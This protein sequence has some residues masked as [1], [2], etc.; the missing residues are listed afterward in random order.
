MWNNRIKITGRVCFLTGNDVTIWD[1]IGWCL[2]L[3]WMWKLWP[4][5][6]GLILPRRLVD[7]Q[8][9]GR[10]ESDPPLVSIIVPA[11][12][13]AAAIEEALRRMLAIDY[14][15]F[16]LIA[17]DDRSSDGTGAIMD[18][19][20]AGDPRCRVIHVADLPAGWLGKNHANR[21]GAREARG[22]YLLFT[23]G[24]VMFEPAILRHAVAAMRGG[25]DHLALFP[26]AMMHGF[27]ESMMMNYFAFQFSF[28]T[29]LSLV[30]FRWAKR[31]FVGIGAFNLVRRSA[32]E[33]AG[34]H[35]R[36]K[37]EVADDLMLGKIV[38]EAG[39]QQD[40]MAGAPLVKV[41]WQSGL[42]GIVR[43]L[44]KNAFAAARYSVP[45]TLTA[46]AIHLFVSLA[47]IALAITGPL[48]LPSIAFVLITLA[49]HEFMAI[50]NRY[51]PLV[52]VLYPVCSVV[53]AYIMARSAYVTLRSGG[54][55]W[56]D[57]FYPLAELR[58][59]MIEWR[60]LR[61]SRRDRPRTV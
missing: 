33:A 11:R 39:F 19:V 14:P 56:R 30:R 58:A 17:I 25:L 49:S 52:A 59:G 27:G 41:K 13:E 36:L 57:S 60:P 53:F 20:A 50:R 45:L 43:G 34:G 26:D 5:W 16:E 51:S 7:V 10:D 8:P 1:V 23:D 28:A 12:D 9:I 2:L 46:I 22:E 47:P 29:Q 38:K 6:Y 42:W 4:I 35:E 44:E 31:A 55:T 32:Y 48:R 61:G 24:D 3:G 15:R 21:L 18:R 37:M 40:A 54:V